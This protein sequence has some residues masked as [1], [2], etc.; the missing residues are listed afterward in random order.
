MRKLQWL[1]MAMFLPLLVPSDPA[2]AED[3]DSG[4]RAKQ[5]ILGWNGDGCL[6]YEKSTSKFGTSVVGLTF[7]NLSTG[8]TRDFFDE[9]NAC[10]QPG[11]IA[12]IQGLKR[13]QA[14]GVKPGGTKPRGLK[15]IV[16]ERG[17][18]LY[19]SIK[20]GR[21]EVPVGNVEL[22]ATGNPDDRRARWK[23]R[24][25][26]W[27]KDGRGMA[28]RV[29]ITYNKQTR[30]DRFYPY[31]VPSFSGRIADCERAFAQTR[32]IAR[33]LQVSQREAAAKML[34]GIRSIQLSA[35]QARTPAQRSAIAGVCRG[36]SAR[37]RKLFRRHQQ[38]RRCL[39]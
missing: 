36:L 29:L 10:P 33:K 27:S 5:T 38:Y 23:L 26:R 18:R 34:A 39:K 24:G 13:V 17:G 4:R 2:H 3:I 14:M 37:F 32:C 22:G 19:F 1:T 8:K 31:A 6:I 35:S 7:H 12:Q 9:E 21:T 20:K 30:T 16:K 25:T 11:T 28:F 15:P